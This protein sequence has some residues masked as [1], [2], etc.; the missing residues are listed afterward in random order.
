MPSYTS[1]FLKK[2]VINTKFFF[3]KSWGRSTW[4]PHP[5][6]QGV[7]QLLMMIRHVWFKMIDLL[8]APPSDSD[9]LVSSS[10][11]LAL[12]FGGS[13][14]DGDAPNRQPVPALRGARRRIHVSLSSHLF[15]WNFECRVIGDYF[16]RIPSELQLFS[17]DDFVC[18]SKL[19]S[20]LCCGWKSWV[21]YICT[22]D[23]CCHNFSGMQ[24]SFQ[25]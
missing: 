10:C 4:C 25:S 24:S 3:R 22:D 18:A 13:D 14:A 21:C 7:K 9:G 11:C 1:F 15:V 8:S 12:P 19:Y 16:V 20:Q 6:I 5:S 23:I 17:G 2:G